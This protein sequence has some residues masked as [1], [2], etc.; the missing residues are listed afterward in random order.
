MYIVEK[1]K[2]RFWKVTNT[3]TV[4]LVCVTV[5]KKGAER[6]A[7]LLNGLDPNGSFYI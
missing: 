2:H 3:S 1:H 6:V 5:Y 7:S 4:T